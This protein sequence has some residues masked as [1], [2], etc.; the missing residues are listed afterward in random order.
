VCCGFGGA[1]FLGR[2]CLKPA[3]FL[4][5]L[6]AFPSAFIRAVSPDARAAFL[7]AI[8]C[9]MFCLAAARTLSRAGFGPLPAA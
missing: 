4:A 2:R 8:S 9:R 7:S 5:A 3:C 6:I 1:A